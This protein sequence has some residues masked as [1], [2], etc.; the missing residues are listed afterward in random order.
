MLLNEREIRNFE[1]S[2]SLNFK[3]LCSLKFRI[4]R[5]PAQPEPQNFK[6]GRALLIKILYLVSVCF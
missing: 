4:L 2:R 6:A 5:L 3:I 1:I